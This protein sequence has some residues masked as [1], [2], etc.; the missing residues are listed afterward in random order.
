MCLTKRKWKETSLSLRGNSSVVAQTYMHAWRMHT[1]HNVQ[2]IRLCVHISPHI[3]HV[4]QRFGHSLMFSSHSERSLMPPPILQHQRD[5]PEPDSAFQYQRTRDWEREREH[6]SKEVFV[7]YSLNPI[8]CNLWKLIWQKP[9]E[10]LT[11]GASE[12]IIGICKNYIYY[13]VNV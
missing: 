1:R 2:Y 8:F 5:W 4:Q 7:K 11:E 13:K 10:L 9:A 3:V 12:V 6:L